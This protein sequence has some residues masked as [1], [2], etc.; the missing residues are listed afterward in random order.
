MYTCVCVYTLILQFVVFSSGVYF[1]V[2]FSLKNVFFF[3]CCYF[4]FLSLSMI[5]I[6]VVAYYD[7]YASPRTR[8]AAVTHA[9][10]SIRAYLPVAGL[11][12]GARAGSE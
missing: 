7:Y 5:V 2:V 1:F 6:I 4:H 12:D 3:F 9:V 8:P 10:Y 11:G